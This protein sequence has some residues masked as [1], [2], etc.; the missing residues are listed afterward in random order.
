VWSPNFDLS[1]I[2][3]WN[4]STEQEYYNVDKND[5]TRWCHL[6]LIRTPQAS[7]LDNIE[8]W[9][10]LTNANY[11][12]WMTA[13]SWTTLQDQCGG[14]VKIIQTL[15]VR[16]LSCYQSVH[17]AA[18]AF[19]FTAMSRWMKANGVKWRTTNQF[20]PQRINGKL[21]AVTGMKWSKNK[22][23]NQPEILKGFQD[24]VASV[25]TGPVI[26]LRNNQANNSSYQEVNELPKHN[27][28]GINKAEW[29]NSTAVSLETALVP[30]TLL[31][32]F[33]KEHW[34]F[35]ISSDEQSKAICHLFAAYRFHQIIYRSTIR[36]SNPMPIDIFSID[37]LVGVCL[38]DYFQFTDAEKAVIQIPLTWKNDKPTG[39]PMKY[40]T[41]EERKQATRDRVRLHRENKKKNM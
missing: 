15:D 14:Q 32:G 29:M 8:S 18:A 34:L 20:E 12:M 41:E 1:T 21:H 17:I 26:A 2:F 16:V 23:V 40:T 4:D 9:R 39:R 38:T 27:S 5:D 3:D 6:R 37:E 30:D 25:A 33:I 10:K 7:M 31:S 36:T 35:D 11:D 24:Y 19:E 28:Y 13:R 22:L